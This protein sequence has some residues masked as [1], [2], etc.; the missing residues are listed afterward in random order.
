M[1]AT[2]SATRLHALA[3]AAAVLGD[4]A[5]VAAA[6]RLAGLDLEEGERAAD[7]LAAAGVLAPSRPLR[8]THPALR[9]A[10]YAC[11]APGER[12]IAHRRAV[13]VLRA[14]GADPMELAV[15][16]CA[17]EPAGDECVAAALIDAGRSALA[18]GAP[19]QAALLLERALAEP[20]ASGGRAPACAPLARAL[21]LLGDP[22]AP[23][24]TAQA[25]AEAA[26]H[27]RPAIA[28]DLIEALWLAGGADVALALACW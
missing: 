13:R 6:A 7:A 19:Q 12:A 14:A 17:A 2:E 9:A 3:G 22:R 18:G 28:S 5:A 21:T 1:R 27:E 20:P 8:F 11:L 25:L 4:G 24:V 10:L 15:H 23:G 16:A 26:P